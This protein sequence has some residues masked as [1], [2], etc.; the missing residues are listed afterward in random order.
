MK[1]TLII[2]LCTLF[3]FSCENK[4][5]TTAPEV[6]D[7]TEQLA[8]NDQATKIEP[9]A[10]SAALPSG[11]Q[12]NVSNYT[13]A[14]WLS[15]DP[16]TQLGAVPVNGVPT[17]PANKTPGASENCDFHIFSWQWFT[18][19]LNPYNE[20]LRNFENRDLYPV[21]DLDTCTSVNSDTAVNKA[22]RGI[23]PAVL[24]V[25]DMPDIPGQAGPGDAL[26]DK[27]TNIVFYNRSFTK[28]ECGIFADGNFPKADAVSASFP[29]K[30]DQVVEIKTSWR[31]LSNTDDASRYYMIEANIEGIGNKQ[32]GL[33]GF[34]VVVNTGAH[35]EF[36]WATFEHKDN[37]PDCN[38]VI[39]SSGFTRPQP[40]SGWTLASQSCNTCI[41]SN[42][43]DGADLKTLCNAQCDFNSN[44]SQP[45]YD[46]NGN[47]LISGA[48][49]QT[50]SNIC[51]DV[52]Y[53]DNPVKPQSV[54]NIPDI[55]YLNTLLVGPDGI[56]TKLD[57]TN[58]MAVLKNYFLGGAEWTDVSKI[59]SSSQKFDTELAGSTSLANS[60][61][62]SY[63]QY[64]ASSFFETG[65][66]S[67]HGGASGDNTALA[68][69]L[70]TSA[71]GAVP[72]L[73]DRCDVKAGFIGSNE[74]AQTVCPT[75]C[76]DAM[77]WNGNWKTITGS[78]MS[79]CGC[80][81]CVSE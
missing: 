37:A 16:I 44:P 11:V 62:E 40:A 68:S 42:Y 18:Y 53:G 56:I 79:V 58:K 45:V 7:T 73:I 61:L 36:I 43:Q 9:M 69:H 28:N 30:V 32:L 81:A 8:V 12:C 13:S 54:H 31:I 17:L 70:L 51:L 52:T 3:L 75:T 1:N 39:P 46:S 55:Q 60:T 80:N 63:T 64:S 14:N 71:E 47:V 65:C 27:N 76:E 22:S 29:T 6:A 35:P 74:Q 21:V 72:G 38:V 5:N 25:I 10:K 33:V 20:E 41:A 15:P 49:G 34:H 77:G 67:C 78:A 2:A 66:M 48:A 50:P 26:Y 59:T 4:E 24:K 19:L 57:K 23:T